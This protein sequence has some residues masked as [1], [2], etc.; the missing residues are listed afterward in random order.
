M[1]SQ[2]LPCP[3]NW[4]LQRY[5]NW[6][7]YARWMSIDGAWA[8]ELEIAAVNQLLEA[9]GASQRLFVL[10]AE[11]GRIAD[12]GANR[13]PCDSDFF[14]RKYHDHFSTLVKASDLTFPPTG[15]SVVHNTSVA[16][17]LAQTKHPQN[18]ENQTKR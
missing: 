1:A 11:E 13:P 8:G 12:I 2:N 3:I 18:R 7:A 16:H 9:A 14:V 6:N 4:S 5:N 10:V 17:F 15:A